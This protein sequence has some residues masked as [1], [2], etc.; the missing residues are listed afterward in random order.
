MRVI[1]R[2]LRMT[3]ADISYRWRNNPSVWKHTE[4]KP[5]RIVTREIERKWLRN[6]IRH[7][8]EK[9]FAIC[10]GDDERYV[11]NVQLTDIDSVSAQFHIF[12]GE[13]SYHGKGVGKKA[14]ILML[15]Y[16]F[17]VLGLDT[18]FLFVHK[19][20]VGAINSYLKCGFLQVDE[21]GERLK[22]EIYN[23]QFRKD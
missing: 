7:P 12:I 9:R 10:A 6:A 5:N 3:D 23:E 4:N 2:P 13:I 21:V 18:V 22:M 8:N 20:N 19:N 11:G 17:S 15:E 14:T 16:A 1:I